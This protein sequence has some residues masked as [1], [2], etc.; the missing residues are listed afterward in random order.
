MKVTIARELPKGTDLAQL[1]TYLED[2]CNCQ[3]GGD[4]L[5]NASGQIC[6]VMEFKPSKLLPDKAAGEAFLNNLIDDFL[7]NK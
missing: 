7:A 6:L 4:R 3:V 2:E 1:A 5:S